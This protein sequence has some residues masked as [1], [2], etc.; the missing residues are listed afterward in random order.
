MEDPEELGGT[1]FPITLGDL[2]K[3]HCSITWVTMPNLDTMGHMV[4]IQAYRGPVLGDSGVIWSAPDVAAVL[5]FLSVLDFT[6]TVFIGYFTTDFSFTDNVMHLCSWP[7]CNRRTI[8]SFM[9]M[10]M[11]MTHMYGFPQNFCLD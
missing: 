8:N 3:A 1:G 6:F 7:Q 11:V 10:M 2:L 5:L 9:M 4:S